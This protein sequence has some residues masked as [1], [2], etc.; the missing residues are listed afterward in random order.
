MRLGFVSS[1][2]P[3][4]R[5]YNMHG[6]RRRALA[7]TSSTRH[8]TRKNPPPSSLY[9][10]SPSPSARTIV[11]ASRTV[12][13]TA[14]SLLIPITIGYQPAKRQDRLSREDA[15]SNSAC[16]AL[17]PVGLRVCA[18]RE[19]CEHAGTNVGR[20]QCIAVGGG[21]PHWK[22]TQALAPSLPSFIRRPHPSTSSSESQ[23]SDNVLC[24]PGLSFSRPY[25]RASGPCPDRP[26]GGCTTPPTGRAGAKASG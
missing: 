26:S 17:P 24:A 12:P 19:G 25:T 22:S 6:R 1:P 11:K 3:A 10:F 5:N 15:L 14:R 13:P 2:S 7:G 4:P 21:A 23:A 8:E 20:G 18:D 9:P 16:L